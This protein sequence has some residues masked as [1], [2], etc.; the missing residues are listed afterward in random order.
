MPWPVLPAWASAKVIVPAS[1]FSSLYLYSETSAEYSLASTVM[2]R[3][4]PDRRLT[5]MG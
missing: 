2:L 5:A 4:L 3:V 1:F